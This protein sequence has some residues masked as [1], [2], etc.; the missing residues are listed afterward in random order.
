MLVEEV[1]EQ[2]ISDGTQIGAQLYVSQ[3]GETYADLA[4]GDSASRC[5]R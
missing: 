2:G 4:L 5:P 1:L 3:G